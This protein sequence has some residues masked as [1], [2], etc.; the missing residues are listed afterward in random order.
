M[1]PGRVL[2]ALLTLAIFLTIA[3]GVPHHLATEDHHDHPDHDS[4]AEPHEHHDGPEHTSADH[5]ILATKAGAPKIDL[6]L[7]AV[8]MI[9]PAEFDAAPPVAAVVRVDR[10]DPSPPHLH[11]AAFGPASP[12]APPTLRV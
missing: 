1:S 11:D 7:A 2:H 9:A 4:P 10:S 3:V 6:R 12:R 8:A 5:E